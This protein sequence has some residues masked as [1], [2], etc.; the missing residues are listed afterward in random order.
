MEERLELSGELSICNIDELFERLTVALA[1]QTQLCIDLGAVEKID[2]AAAQV[3]VSAK[4]E[5]KATGAS[6][7]FVVPPAIRLWLKGIGIQ[8]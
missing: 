3:L 4:N 1:Q 7:S 8:L 5:A 6:L 2:T